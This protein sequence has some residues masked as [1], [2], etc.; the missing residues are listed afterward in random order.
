VGLV[1]LSTSLAKDNFLSDAAIHR[2]NSLKTTWTAGK[3]FGP[4]ITPKYIR[5]LLGVRPDAHKYRLPEAPPID[6]ADDDIPESFDAREK[7]PECRTLQEVRDQGGCGSCWA[8]AAV[9]SMSDRLCIAS[10]GK[11]NVSLS[12]EDLVSC[13][14]I[15]GLGCNGGYPSMAWQYFKHWGLVSGGYLPNKREGCMDYSIEPCEHHVDG[16]RS[17]CEDS[18]T[19]KCSKK[20]KAESG[21]TYKKDL[22]F[23]KSAYSVS[24]DVKAIQKE[25][26]TNGPVEF[27]FDVYDDFPSY[28][29]G[30]YQQTS[31]VYEGGHAV[32]AI[33]WGTED[34]TPYWLIV[35]SWNTD[36]GLNGTFKIIRG[37]NECNIESQVVAGIP[38]V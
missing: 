30:V 1:G 20:C 25:I 5:G 3:N 6:L 27:A 19:P 22:Y 18:S 17:T 12:A 33:G 7:W 2:I 14:H 11:V 34:G 36:W 32:K 10:Q 8:V 23:A 26:M 9:T 28:K 15:C 21:L 13:C 4:H 31:S 16:P 35:N 29:S 37:K 24:S 38:K